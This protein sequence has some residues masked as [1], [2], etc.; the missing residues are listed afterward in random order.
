[1]LFFLKSTN[2][3]RLNKNENIF[4]THKKTLHLTDYKDIFTKG[5]RERES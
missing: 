5:E 1:M 3:E 4:P 2:V